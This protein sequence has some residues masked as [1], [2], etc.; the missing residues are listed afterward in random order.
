MLT[1]N[2]HFLKDHKM[3]KDRKKKLSSKTS[4][5]LLPNNNI[6]KDMK[7]L[8]IVDFRGE[9]AGYENETFNWVTCFA[10]NSQ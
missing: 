4:I 7:P 9:G 2:S 6:S 3:Q 10:T 8:G 5:S 1:T